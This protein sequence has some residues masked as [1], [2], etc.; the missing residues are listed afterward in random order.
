MGGLAFAGTVFKA[1]TIFFALAGVI[2]V[3]LESTAPDSPLRRWLIRRWQALGQCVWRA[4]PEQLTRWLL[5]KIRSL[6]RD[7]F[8]EVDESPVFG[9]LFVGMVFILLPG[10]ALLNYLTGGTAF[11]V[12]FF[13]SLAA[14]LVILNF[15][16]E[17][18]ALGP[19]NAAIAVYLGLSLILVLPGYVLWSF[20]TAILRSV[21][22][23]AVLSSILTAVLW[24]LAAYGLMLF[25]DLF[26]RKKRMDVAVPAVASVVHT[27]LS[28]LP[29]AFVLTFLALLA[30][31]LMI[32]YQS[33]PVT[34]QLLISTLIFSSASL[35]ATLG[36]MERALKAGAALA[37]P[38]AY[39]LSIV[40]ASGLSLALLYFAYLASPGEF[41]MTEAV[42]VLLGLAPQGGKIFLGPDFWIM[43]LAFLP[44]L[45]F[46]VAAAF[47]WLAKGIS[48]PQRWLFGDAAFVAK[49]FLAAGLGFVAAAVLLWGAG[50]VL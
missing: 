44:I 37:L 28:V 47:A 27:F 15:S 42:N 30:G 19:L 48:V 5:A 8:E 10:A 40:V 3:F 6:I 20:T 14:A 16:G 24:Y 17:I 38:A 2:A 22:T 43:H 46:L 25:F 33:P 23:H 45:V 49:P 13:L 36:I 32:P 7:H 35:I 31:H 26:C 50:G 39:L 9:A 29:V 12:L 21:F 11:L 34:W 41:T 1:L 18:R 4:I